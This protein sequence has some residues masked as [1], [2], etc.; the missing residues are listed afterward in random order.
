M[1][2][3]PGHPLQRFPGAL[4]GQ[5][6]DQDHED[7]DQRRRNREDREPLVVTEHPGQ[8]GY[9]ARSRQHH[10]RQ[11]AGEVSS[12]ARRRFD[13]RRRGSPLCSAA[14]PN[15]HRT[16]WRASF[17][18]SSDMTGPRQEAAR[19]SNPAAAATRRPRSR[20]ARPATGRPRRRVPVR[21]EDP[22]ITLASRVADDQDGWKPQ[23]DR[24][25][26]GDCELHGWTRPAGAVFHGRLACALSGN[27]LPRP[28]Y[29]LWSDS[30]PLPASTSSGQNKS[31]GDFT[32]PNPFGRKTVPEDPVGSALVEQQ[33]HPTSTL[34]RPS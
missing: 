20:P 25:D 10:L 4:L 21:E 30:G 18:R 9:E 1:R 17:S 27:T 16:G 7:D 29:A 31:I 19:L 8:H 33:N 15:V 34:R 28:G 2:R 13:R 12:P 26:R 32:S 24:H 3:Q 6:S 22:A 23:A 14:W 11:V 5:Q